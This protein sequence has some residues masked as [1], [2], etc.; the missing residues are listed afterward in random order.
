MIDIDQLQSFEKDLTEGLI[1]YDN[2][3]ETA[4]GLKISYVQIN[5]EDG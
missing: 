1:Q 4:E 3:P 5:N 2:D